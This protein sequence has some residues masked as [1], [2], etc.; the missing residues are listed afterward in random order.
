MSK[1]ITKT[2]ALLILN[3]QRE[4]RATTLKPELEMTIY[5]LLQR[6][7]VMAILPTDFDMSMIFPVFAMAKEEMSSL[8]TCMIPFFSLKSTVDNQISEMLSLSCTVEL[9]TATVNLL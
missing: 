1:K 2:G 7:D 3:I 5:S 4:N 6:R 8:K 9:M